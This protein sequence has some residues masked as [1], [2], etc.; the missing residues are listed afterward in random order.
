MLKTA[1]GMPLKHLSPT[2]REAY[3]QTCCKVFF[4]TATPFTRAAICRMAGTAH[5]VKRNKTLPRLAA[6]AEMVI[7]DY[8]PI[9]KTYPLDQVIVAGTQPDCTMGELLSFSILDISHQGQDILEDLVLR[10]DGKTKAKAVQ[11]VQLPV[12]HITR[13]RRAFWGKALTQLEVD[14]LPEEVEEVAPA[15]LFFLEEIRDF[16][17]RDG[18]LDEEQEGEGGP[19][20]MDGVEQSQPRGGDLPGQRDGQHTPAS[21]QR[22][23]AGS[24]QGGA[25]SSTTHPPSH[26]TGGVAGV[27]HLVHIYHQLSLLSNTTTWI[28]RGLREVAAAGRTSALRTVKQV[29]TTQL[30]HTIS[31]TLTLTPPTDRTQKNRNGDPCSAVQH[32]PHTQRRDLP[33]PGSTSGSYLSPY[34]C[35]RKE[36]DSRLGNSTDKFLPIIQIYC[37]MLPSVCYWHPSSWNPVNTESQQY[38]GGP[39]P[40]PPVMLGTL[41]TNFK[42]DWNLQLATCTWHPCPTPL[43]PQAPQQHIGLQTATWTSS[44]SAGGGRGGGPPLPTFGSSLYSPITQNSS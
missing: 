33:S 34:K 24:N 37:L 3:M 10:E 43:P 40:Q 18:A 17:G 15:H 26:H 13:A 44:Y 5:G 22:T 9:L 30:Q 35:S 28:C 12:I 20:D 41:V 2:D 14:I 19:T 32:W 38:K 29:N 36:G 27:S 21:S 39:T 42:K 4:T 11:Q 6:Q 25:A 8:Q 31:D 7:Q 23:P 16:M 1:N